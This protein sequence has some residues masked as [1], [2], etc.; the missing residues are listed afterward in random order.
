[1]KQ[2]QRKLKAI[3][4][5]VVLI[6]TVQPPELAYAQAK[7]VSAGITGTAIHPELQ[8]PIRQNSS[9]TEESNVI[10]DQLQGSKD[11]ETELVGNIEV[12]LIS[13]AV[14]SDVEFTVDPLA[15]FDA[16]TKPDGQI[17]SP[18]GLSVTNHSVV[19]VKLEIA[20]V[21][22]VSNLVFTDKFPGGPV[23]D[24][25][26]VETVAET[27]APGRAILVLGKRNQTYE[28]TRTFEQYAICP[29]K[30][31]IPVAEIDAE[32]TVE[33]QIYGKATADF[34]GAYQFTVKPT[35]KISTV[36]AR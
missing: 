21:D 17:T 7:T 5:A 11:V 26:L 36:K 33:L 15:E 13:A 9:V 1:M 14:P 3:M 28:N 10:F 24:F 8:H 20:S 18:Q 32:A 27:E 23:Q 19:P 22:P 35:L 25:A 16:V 4:A 30:K 31:G 29:G 2:K 6:L 34:Y 12:T